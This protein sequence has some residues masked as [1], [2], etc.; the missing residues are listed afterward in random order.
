M[1]TTSLTYSKVIIVRRL[2]V[3]GVITILGLAV[4]TGFVLLQTDHSIAPPHIRV[5]DWLWRVFICGCPV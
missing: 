5:M 4:T 3:I 1:S 2:L